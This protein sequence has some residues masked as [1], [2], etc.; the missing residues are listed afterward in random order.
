ME[1]GEHPLGPVRTQRRD[2]DDSLGEDIRRV[3]V[4][5]GQ[6][7]LAPGGEDGDAELDTL[8]G[9]R[10]FFW[11]FPLGFSRVSASVS[12]TWER[13]LCGRRTSSSTR[14]SSARHPPSFDWSPLRRSHSRRPRGH[15]HAWESWNGAAELEPLRPAA[16]FLGPL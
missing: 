4:V 15:G 3:G 10:W 6:R 9:A 5:A 2:W 11:S 13:P 7:K 14:L 12:A 8:A 1:T 16:A